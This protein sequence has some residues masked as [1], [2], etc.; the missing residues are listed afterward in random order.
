MTNHCHPDQESAICRLLEAIPGI[1]LLDV[2]PIVTLL[3]IIMGSKLYGTG[4]GGNPTQL[5]YLY[6]LPL[7]CALLRVTL[8]VACG[9]VV[10]L[11][12]YLY[13]STVASTRVLLSAD[14]VRYGT[15]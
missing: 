11:Y 4:T 15:G 5:S 12:K 13:C 3:I 8:P 6:L 1:P 7:K 14:C 10:G 2:L 9:G